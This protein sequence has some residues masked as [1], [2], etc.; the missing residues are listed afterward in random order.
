M[1]RRKGR[2]L[3][4][5]RTMDTDLRQAPRALTHSAMAAT[6][7]VS[8]VGRK[9][10]RFRGSRRT[11]SIFFRHGVAPSPAPGAGVV[12]P[13]PARHLDRGKTG[14]RAELRGHF[15]LADIR[16]RQHAGTTRFDRRAAQRDI[17]EFL[18]LISELGGLD[19]PVRARARQ[20][21]GEM[22]P[23]GRDQWTVAFMRAGR[24]DMRARRRS[25]VA[26]ARDRGVAGRECRARRSAACPWSWSTSA[27]PARVA[28]P[29]R[30]RR[31]CSWP[32]P[33]RRA[34]SQPARRGRCRAGTSRRAGATGRAE[35]QRLRAQGGIA[36]D[37]GED[38][39]RGKGFGRGPARGPG[40]APTSSRLA[41]AK[42]GRLSPSAFRLAV[43]AA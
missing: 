40:P 26:A 12:G 8:A 41:G 13:G 7:W 31:S 36:V 23:V 5:Q 20:A 3:A 24:G 25:I 32:P 33:D 16:L 35:L 39:Q 1:R 21:L 34:R 14:W 2:N 10:D 22:A 42:P 37:Q 38:L 9:A 27:R 15:H 29:R 28:P 19:L 4:S 17:G 30:S 11:R 6:R 43:T 18:V